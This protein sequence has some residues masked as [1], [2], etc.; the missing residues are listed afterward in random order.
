APATLVDPMTLTYQDTDG[1]DVAVRFS[2]PLLDAANVDSLFGFD[3]GPIAGNATPQRLQTID[4]SG[5]AAQG[6]SLA[7]TASPSATHGGDGL[8]KLGFLNSPGIY[9]AAA[10]PRP[11]CRWRPARWGR[12]HL[13][14]GGEVLSTIR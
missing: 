14:H 3:T 7:V 4:L 2:R 13:G 11:H 12:H 6:I 9:L 5:V 8:L 1:D 10:R